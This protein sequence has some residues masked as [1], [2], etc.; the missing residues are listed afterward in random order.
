ML[1]LNEMTILSFE[2]AQ[3]DVIGHE[4]GRLKAVQMHIRP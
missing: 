3:E 1:K 2:F 4:Y